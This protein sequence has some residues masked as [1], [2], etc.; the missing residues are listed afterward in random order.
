MEEHIDLYINHDDSNKLKTLCERIYNYC[1]KKVIDVL[2][3]LN[4][5]SS[6]SYHSHIPSHRFSQTFQ[7]QK[8]N[9]EFGLYNI[10]E[11]RDYVDSVIL[12]YNLSED[13][14]RKKNLTL[15]CYKRLSSRF[16]PNYLPISKHIQ[17]IYT[18][19]LQL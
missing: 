12:T 11:N 15:I 14:K 8:F 9:N 2:N 4:S 17:D 1:S 18:E 10:S 3:S 19:I 13:S 5:E 6:E 16:L 7:Y